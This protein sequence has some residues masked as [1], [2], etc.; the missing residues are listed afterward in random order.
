MLPFLKTDAK[1]DS[2]YA[3]RIDSDFQILTMCFF[4]L[5]LYFLNLQPSTSGQGKTGVNTD[6]VEDLKKADSSI[7]DIYRKSPDGGE[8]L[9]QQPIP[10]SGAFCY[11]AIVSKSVSGNE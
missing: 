3:V 11:L 5:F 1:I 6:W 8:F 2:C 4:I 9:S 10:K 7:P